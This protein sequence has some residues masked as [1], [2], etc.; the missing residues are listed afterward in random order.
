MPVI[1]RI[2]EFA[3][4]LTE[5]RQHLHRHPELGFDCH[6][7][8]GFV[9]ARLRDFGVDE[10][11]EGIATSGLVA[12]IEG[13]GEGPT[14]GLRAD[15]DALPI[16]EA[17]GVAHASTVAGRMHACGHDGH[18]TMLLG[19]ARY[20]AETRNFAGR[21]ALIFQPAEEAGGGAGVMCDEGVLE[22]FG[23]AQ[24]YAL[25]TFAG[26]PAGRFM[27]RPG[28]MLAAVDTLTVKVTG[29]GGHGAHPEDCADPVAAIVAM[30][31]A[32]QTI[33]SRNR[34]GTDALVLSV[35][36]IEAGAN[37][38]DN[39]IPE[40]GWFRATVRTYDASVQ[41]MVERRSAEI[42][43]GVAAAMGVGADVTYERGYPATVNDPGSTE[44]ALRIAAEVSGDAADCDPV[45]G[46]EDFSYMLARRPG[47]YLFLGQG[48]GVPVHHPKFDFNDAVTPLG[49]SWFARMVE[50]LQPRRAG[51]A[52]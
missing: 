48:A 32:L 46:A 49:A 45:M 16:T 22:R 26:A 12:I 25:H 35:T 47:T 4:Q 29:R 19:A 13:Q 9:A 34:K 50:T 3:P 8:A 40:S 15:M 11:H 33:V 6:Q 1:N 36:Q 20:L 52:V 37:G 43:Q 10:L 28:P 14:T 38:A 30:V 24:V 5:W 21:V 42:V 17:T 44:H 23:I 41:D 2:A 18:T 39:I 51:R 7:T 27:G 31:G